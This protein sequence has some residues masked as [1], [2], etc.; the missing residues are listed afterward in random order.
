MGPVSA[1]PPVAVWPRVNACPSGLICKMGRQEPPQQR[2]ATKSKIQEEAAG[3]KSKRLVGGLEVMG[4]ARWL[5]G[6]EREGRVRPRWTRLSRTH[7][8][9][10]PGNPAKR[11]CRKQRKTLVSPR[12]PA[13]PSLAG[14][15]VLGSRR[16]GSFMCFAPL[17]QASE[18]RGLSTLPRP[19]AATPENSHLGGSTEEHL[20]L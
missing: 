11:L 3:E 20:V 13:A 17:S 4:Q 15:L 1:L 9:A 2:Q 12:R 8:E 14:G 16:G 19:R 5:F 7:L 18:Q 10:A 6:R